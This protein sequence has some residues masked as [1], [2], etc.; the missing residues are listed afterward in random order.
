MTRREQQYGSNA[1][2]EKPVKTLWELVVVQFED[3]ILRILCY[4]AAVSLVMGVATEG[5]EKGW[6]EGFAIFVAVIIIVSVTAINDYK[7]EQQFRKLYASAESR[8]MN[9]IRDGSVLNTSIYN[10][11]VGDVLLLEDGDSIPVDGIVIDSNELTTDESN[12]TG[13]SD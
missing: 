3:E 7:K 13:E 6:M 2:V 1:A 11:L 8:N 10:I 9:V 12:V 4:A 5:I